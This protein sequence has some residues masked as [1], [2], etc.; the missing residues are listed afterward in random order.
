MNMQRIGILGASFNPPTLGHR[1]V[2]NQAIPHFDEILLVPSVAHAFGKSLIPLKHRLA[3][4]ELFLNEWKNHANKTSIK[5]SLIEKML[6]ENSTTQGPIYTYD[7]LSA[8]ELHYAQFQ[9]PFQICFIIGPDIKEPTIWQKFYRYQDIEK[10]WPLFIAK[11]NLPIH[12]SLVREI[13]LEHFDNA[14]LRKSALRQ[15]VGPEIANYIEENK[16]YRERENICE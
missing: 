1:D 12:S 9:K 2:V 6:N 11:E 3:M 16:L 10:K 5:I 7:V 14:L 4:L 8:L 13:C 15:L